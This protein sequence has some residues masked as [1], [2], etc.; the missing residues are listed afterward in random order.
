MIEC[1]GGISHCIDASDE[2][3]TINHNCAIE[4]I[5]KGKKVV[6]YGF[7]FYG[8]MG[9][10]EDKQKY[11]R[12]K[13]QVSLSEFVLATLMLYPRYKIANQK[14]FT[15]AL[16]ALEYEKTQHNNPAKPKGFLGRIKA[17]F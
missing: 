2:I 5:I 8:G 3:H 6:T 1:E 10:T 15:S 7:A 9:F 17:W 4:A 14:G 11:P 12:P 16:Y 13:R